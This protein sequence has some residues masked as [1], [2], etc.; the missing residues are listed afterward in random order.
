MWRPKELLPR[1]PLFVG[2]RLGPGGRVFLACFVAVGK[3]RS[4]V[5]SAFFFVPVMHKQ[6]NHECPGVGKAR[7]FVGGVFVFSEVGGHGLDV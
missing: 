4:P 3:L 1:W 6:K 2:A 7:N 5:R